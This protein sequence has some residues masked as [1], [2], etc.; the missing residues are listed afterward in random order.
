MYRKNKKFYIIFGISVLFMVFI[1][2]IFNL[3]KDSNPKTTSSMSSVESNEDVNTEVELPT[4]SET[5]IEE[6]SVY[7]E[8]KIDYKEYIATEG[9]IDDSTVEYLNSKLKLIPEKL[10]LK[11]F[12]Q[13]GKILLTDKDISNTYY[14]EYNFGNVIGIHDAKKNI[15][16]ISNSE[17]AIDNALIHEFGHVLDSLTSW[18]SMSTTFINIFNSEKDTLD[19]YSVDNHYKKNEREF[20]AE[21]FQQY[22]LDSEGCKSS[23]PLSYDFI[24]KQIDSLM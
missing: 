12:E 24:E 15:V 8:D 16:Y 11:Y 23:A 21:A 13:N 19:V 2:F 14:K 4:I 18:E 9:A 6:S 22:I 17:H 1:L 10:V 7:E 5:E 3:N 20:F